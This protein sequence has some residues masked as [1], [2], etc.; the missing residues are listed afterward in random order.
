MRNLD[1]KIECRNLALWMM[2]V[3]SFGWALG[4]LP[5]AILS[6]S[7]AYIC[8][9]WYQMQ[10]INDWL[11]SHAENPPP[12]SAGL[13]GSVF[14]GIYQLQITSSK[15]RDRLQKSVDYLQD[16]F[17]SLDDAAVILNETGSITWSNDAARRTLGL[18]FPEDSNQSLVNLIRSPEF[19]RYFESNDYREGL[20]IISPYNDAY[21][22][23]ITITHF[24]KGSRLMFARDVTETSRLQEMRKDF[25]ANVSHEL[26]TPL[27]VINGYLETL[28]DVDTAGVTEDE[29]RWRRAIEQMLIQSR[30]MESLIKD[31]IS[32][33]RLESV[34]EQSEQGLIDVSPMIERIREE[35]LAMVKG[36][37]DI[38]VECDDSIQLQGNP[39]EIHSAFANLVLNAAK[40]TPENGTI[41]IRWYRR[42]PHQVCLTVEDNGDGID[43]HHIPRLTERFY[44]V[45]KSRSIDTGGTGLGLAI[46]KHILFRHQ[47]ELSITS[48][49]GIGSNFTCIFPHERSV[50]RSNIA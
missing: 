7:L 4:I 3:G 22:L 10:R 37:R 46:V 27:T 29:L 8:W 26:R 12:E 49:L 14:D 18:R 17:A 25:V 2:L 34:S 6:V 42:S 28:M 31:L 45:D 33:S 24:G 35:A 44:R 1:W 39:G 41:W 16:S 47:A 21:Q 11:Y 40:Y 38:I 36:K 20:Q 19:I 5:W 30:R 15:E 50:T 48:E 43:S 32:L 9:T 13:W 23:L